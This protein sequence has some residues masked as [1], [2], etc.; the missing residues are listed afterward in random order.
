MSHMDQVS[1]KAPLKR[2]VMSSHLEFT[3]PLP[4]AKHGIIN[5]PQLY[6]L[7]VDNFLDMSYSKM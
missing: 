5:V 3:C 2:S 4:T 6:S 1:L 7:F